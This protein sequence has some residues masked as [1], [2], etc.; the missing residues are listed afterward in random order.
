MG[1][2]ALNLFIVDDNKMVVTGL[3]N[4]L[5]DKF[6]KALNISTFATGEECLNNLDEDTNVVILDYFL[7]DKNG[8]EV[9]KSIKK[10]NPDTE[11][12]MLSSNE[13]VG[14]II[15]SFRLGAKDFVVKDIG[16]WEKI[17][18]LVNR[19]FTAPIHFVVREFKVTKY[20]A[21][22]LLTFFTMLVVVVLFL[23]F[24]R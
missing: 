12:I 15:E 16:A 19:I 24:M 2:Q 8:N 1:T 6:G 20:V 17:I 18:Q 21:I 10:M 22:F 23:A 4:Y 11:V 9:L 7:E 13:E 14:V 3:K 5:K